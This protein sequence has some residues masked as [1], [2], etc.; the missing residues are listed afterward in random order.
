MANVRRE[1]RATSDS[2]RRDLE[3]LAALENQ[4][5]TLAFDDPRLAD[6]A[7]QVEEIAARLLSRSAA[8]SSLTDA[9]SATGERG[10]IETTRRPP[11]EILAEWRELERRAAVAEPGSAEATEVTVLIDRVRAEYRDAFD[12]STARPGQPAQPL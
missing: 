7:R 4:K 11:S 2:L 9:V 5:R 6:L 8:Q 1:L 10:T 3:A 12:A